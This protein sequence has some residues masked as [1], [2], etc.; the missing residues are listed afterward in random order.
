MVTGLWTKLTRI[1]KIGAQG[2]QKGDFRGQNITYQGI[3]QTKTP[4]MWQM[5]LNRLF[6]IVSDIFHE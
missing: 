5:K 3:S 2:P 4:K 6:Q 1:M